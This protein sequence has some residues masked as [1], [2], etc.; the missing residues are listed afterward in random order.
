MAT[1]RTVSGERDTLI[2][3]S[4]AAA[5]LGVHANTIRAWTEAG[6]LTAWRINARG[7]RRYRRSDVEAVL[8]PDL[9]GPMAGQ[10]GN[11]VGAVELASLAQVTTATVGISSVNAVCRV[12]IDSLRELG[13]LT[14]VAI[15]LNRDGAPVLE[16]HA[17]YRTAPPPTLTDEE[18]EPGVS[19]LSLRGS[20]DELG[21]LVVEDDDSGATIERR[22]SFLEA[23]AG[24][25]GVALHHARLMSRARRELTRARALRKVTQ[26]LTGQLE[27]DEVLDDIVDRTRSLFDA[28]KVGLWMITENTYPFGLAASRDIGDEFAAAVSTTDHGHALARGVRGPRPGDQGCPTERV[29][30]VRRRHAPGVP[31]GGP[32]VGVP[33]SAGG[34]RAGRR[35]ARASITCA[36]GI[37]RRTSWHWS[38]P[39]PTR[40][41]SPSTMPACIAAWPTRPPECGRSTTCRTA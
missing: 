6:R 29:Q 22:R 18:Y 33:G 12:A 28:D 2:S 8:A 32:A 36:T 38:R 31:G 7:D 4:Q 5:L 19:R 24:T 41:P 15:Y 39:S 26:E 10:A 3:V 23:L 21:V 30:G 14:R 1:L 16:A 40:L 35:P 20:E 13:D 34:P 17:G 27:L 11:E 37:G 9:D 25:V